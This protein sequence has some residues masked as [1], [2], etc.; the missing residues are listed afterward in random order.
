MIWILR[1]AAQQSSQTATAFLSWPAFVREGRG[2]FLWEAFVSGKAKS[3][4]HVDDAKAAIRAFQDRLPTPKTS[5]H[6]PGEV[7]SLIGAA[8]LRT[9]W[10]K[11]V[12]ILAE[13][14]LV[15]MATASPSR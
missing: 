14:C 3:A 11:D 5:V 12:S 4:D 10:A 7:Q 15:V 8:L 13:Q 6:V 2:L 1:E 9:G